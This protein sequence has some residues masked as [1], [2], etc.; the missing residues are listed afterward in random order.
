MQ[1]KFGNIYLVDKDSSRCGLND[2]E[3]SKKKLQERSSR[4]EQTDSKCQCL[5]DDFPAP[6]RPQIP[7]FSLGFWNI[8]SEHAS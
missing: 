3:E 8:W 1:T 4:S 5:T 7:I 2:S 6:V